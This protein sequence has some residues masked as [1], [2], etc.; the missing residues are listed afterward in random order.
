METTI[1]ITSP[2]VTKPMIKI[3]ELVRIT[4]QKRIWLRVDTAKS[5][6]NEEVYSMKPIYRPAPK[7]RLKNKTIFSKIKM[8]IHNN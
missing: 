7:S 3:G 5:E 1:T 6:D 8:Q 4:G 2:S